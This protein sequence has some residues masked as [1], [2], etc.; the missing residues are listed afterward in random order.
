MLLCHPSIHCSMGSAPV[1]VQCP[2]TS[3]LGEFPGYWDWLWLSPASVGVHRL[4]LD[5]LPYLGFFHSLSFTCH[6]ISFV[7]FSPWRYLHPATNPP[8]SPGIG[9]GTG[10]QRTLRRSFMSFMSYMPFMLYI[11]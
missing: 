1:G 5:L 6:W 10:S 3:S 7:Y 4:S 11:P 8:P 2:L 9:I